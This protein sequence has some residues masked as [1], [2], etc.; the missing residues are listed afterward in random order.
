[1]GKKDNYSKFLR[2]ETKSKNQNEMSWKAISWIDKH[3]NFIL[4]KPC[5]I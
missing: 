1:M 4:S 2:E 3:V 5:F